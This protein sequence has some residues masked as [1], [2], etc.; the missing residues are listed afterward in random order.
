[1]LKVNLTPVERQIFSTINAACDHFA[2]KTTV[3]AAGGWV[4]DKLLG[5]H[6]GGTRFDCV[7]VI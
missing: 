7:K 6:S 5:L 3:R 1:M 4:R 2:L